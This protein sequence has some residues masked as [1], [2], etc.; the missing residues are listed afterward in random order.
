MPADEGVPEPP[1]GWV[2]GDEPD[3]A[4]AERAAIEGEEPQQTAAAPERKTTTRSLAEMLADVVERAKSGVKAVGVSCCHDRLE[5][6]LAGFRPKMVT[7]FGARTSFGKSSYAIMVADEALKS[8][9]KVL[10]FSVE[11]SEETYAQRFM[12]RRAFVNAYNLRANRC[13]RSEIARM[14]EQA[15]A[16][17]R[18]PFF[19]DAIG[20]TGE[21]I[22]ARIREEHQAEP[23][24]LV[25]IDYIQRVAS[26]KRTQDVRTG[27]THVMSIICDAVKQCG[28][29]AL[30]LSQ[31][32]RPETG[33]PSKEPDLHD[34]KESGDIEN[35]AE[36]VVLGWVVQKGDDEST[37]ERFLKIPKNKDGPVDTR[38]API[39]FDPTTASFRVWKDPVREAAD[40]I[41][42]KWDN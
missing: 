40:G 35:M 10:L 7:V 9:K 38:A 21:Q 22:A 3:S 33:N 28:A 5:Y 23:I 26:G 36:H 14:E 29:A 8:G 17:Q 13:D 2:E 27:I 12:A 32:K 37:Q 41:D 4:D 42:M 1:E 31:L 30:V 11:D 25:I 20:W 19:V 15:R 39:E 18:T 6:A 16:A 34:L 24:A